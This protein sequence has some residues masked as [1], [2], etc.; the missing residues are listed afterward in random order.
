MSMIGFLQR[1]CDLVKSRNRAFILPPE[2]K[3]WSAIKHAFL[4]VVFIQLPGCE[5]PTPAKGVTLI[6]VDTLRADHLGLYGYERNT[7]PGLDQFSKSALVFRRAYSTSAWTLPSVASLMTGQIPPDHGARRSA[8]S[9]DGAFSAIR[10]SSP[11]LASIL[12]QHD[13]RTAAFINNPFLSPEFGFDRGFEHYDYKRATNMGARSA[14]EMVDNAID[15]LDKHGEQPYFLLVHLFDP[16]LNYN[17]P[18]P[19]KGR[20]TANLPTNFGATHMDWNSLRKNPMGLDADDRRFVIAAYDEEIA[21]VDAAL[22]RFL[23]EL[24]EAR[25]LERGCVILTSDHG[26]EFFEHDGF[27][28]GHQVWQE[29]LHVPLIVWA[30][31]VTPGVNDEPVSLVDIFP[32]VLDFM[33][34]T[35][36]TSDTNSSLWPLID[37]GTRNSPGNLFAESSLY[38]PKCAAL[39]RWPYKLIRTESAPLQLFNLESDPNEQANR[40]EDFPSISLSMTAELEALE[41]NSKSPSDAPATLDQSTLQELETLGYLGEDH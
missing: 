34:A 27:E 7:S 36:S 16:H 21:G 2:C 25:Y 3:S 33:G 17:A 11:S 28:H 31:R 15:W 14:S 20:F 23:Q 19:F 40:A 35:I 30:Q 6:V 12:S 18:K 38:G 26:E 1:L 32:T 29:L 37:S 8:D 9:P 39:I 24:Q 41:P 10:K 5:Q 4:L 13:V 22:E